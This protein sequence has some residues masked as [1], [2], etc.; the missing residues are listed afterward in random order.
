MEYNGLYSLEIYEKIY[1]SDKNVD[2]Y[3]NIIDLTFEN[4]LKK[5]SVVLLLLRWMQCVKSIMD[6]TLT[7]FVFK[8]NRKFYTKRLD[9]RIVTLII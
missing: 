4:C 2:R 1:T 5:K 8:I 3:V 9:V 6:I 7:Q